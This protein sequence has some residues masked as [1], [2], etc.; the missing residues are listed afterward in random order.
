MLSQSNEVM[1]SRLGLQYTCEDSYPNK[2]LY[3]V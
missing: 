2:D 1:L 3:Y